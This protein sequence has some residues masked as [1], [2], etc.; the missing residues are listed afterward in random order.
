MTSRLRA[1]LSEHALPLLGALAVGGL[2]LLL[3]WTL[4][5]SVEMESYDP[6][7]HD[8][9]RVVTIDQ[10]KQKECLDRYPVEQRRSVGYLHCT[11][12]YVYERRQD[13]FVDKR[14]AVAP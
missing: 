2:A 1:K 10:A 4:Q 9:V 8:R 7:K 6:S 5:T 13:F 3:L 12:G 14:P 11:E